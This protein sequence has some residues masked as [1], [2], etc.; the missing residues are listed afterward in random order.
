MALAEPHQRRW[1]ASLA[2]AV[3]LVLQL[4]LPSGIRLGNGYVLPGL[5]AL[6]L[7]PVVIGNPLVLTRDHPWLRRSAIGLG[8]AVVVTNAI[9]LARLVLALIRGTHVTAGELVLAAL[10]ILTT[11]VVACGLVLWELDRGGPFARDPGH[12]RDEEPADLLFP[13][14]EY[15]APLTDW[16]PGF[17]DYLYVGFTNSTAFSPTDTMPLTARAKLVFMMTSVVALLCIAL[18]AARAA[19]LF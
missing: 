4:L 13:Q 3:T 17:L 16:R 11:N 9:T 5:Q 12:D 15:G 18:V 8:V 19:N 10:V 14:T 6:L 2:V 1:P 7:A